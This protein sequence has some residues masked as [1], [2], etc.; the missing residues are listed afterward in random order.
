MV[1][2]EAEGGRPNYPFDGEARSSVRGQR[3]THWPLLAGGNPLL[4]TRLRR[5]VAIV[6]Q[7]FL[8]CPNLRPASRPG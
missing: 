7:L 6:M 1:A 8:T 5:V 4:A 2:A 3:W